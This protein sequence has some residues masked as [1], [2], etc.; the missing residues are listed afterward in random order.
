[1]ARG[2]NRQSLFQDQAAFQYFLDRLASMKELYPTKIFHYCLMSNHIHLLVQAIEGPNL[3]KFMHGLLWGFARWFQRRSSYI[4]H[5]WQGRYKNP[6]IADEL[7]FMEVG[8]YI[9]RNPLRAGLVT[10]LEQYPWS[11]YGYYA[12]GAKDPLVDEDPYYEHVGSTSARRQSAY[13]EFISLAGAH[14]EKLDQ[15][16]FGGRLR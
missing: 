12:H 7:Y 4:G 16:L 6:F 2:N 13:R 3:S 11:S 5:V 9:E 14:D 15:D 8:R 1:M 10:Q